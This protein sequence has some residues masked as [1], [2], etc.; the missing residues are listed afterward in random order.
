MSRMSSEGSRL[1]LFAALG[2]IGLSAGCAERSG[3]SGRGASAIAATERQRARWRLAVEVADETR[4]HAA[5]NGQ[6]TCGGWRYSERTAPAK[7]VRGPGH[8][9]SGGRTG[10]A[11]GIRCR[12]RVQPA[13]PRAGDAG[14]VVRADAVV[15][16]GGCVGRTAWNRRRPDRRRRSRR[17]CPA[18]RRAGFPLRTRTSRKRRPRR[19][20]DSSGRIWRRKTSGRAGRPRPVTARMKRSPGRPWRKGRPYSARPR[21]SWPTKR[22]RKRKTCSAALGRSLPR[23]PTAGPTRPWK[24]MPCSSKPKASSSPTSIPRP[25]TPTAGC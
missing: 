9:G 1:C 18:R 7:H 22:P 15:E 19:N 17:N 25:T 24:R 4:F 23:R 3:C 12:R 21:T 6:R 13:D 10:Y 14:H 11:G 2:L 16:R 8:G 5:V 20:R